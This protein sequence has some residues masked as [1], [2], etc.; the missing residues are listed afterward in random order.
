MQNVCSKRRIKLLGTLD[1]SGNFISAKNPL[2]FLRDPKEVQS[3]LSL[4][5]LRAHDCPARAKRLAI[6]HP[7][8]IFCLDACLASVLVAMRCVRKFND[9]QRGSHL[10][11]RSLALLETARDQLAATDLGIRTMWADFMASAGSPRVGP[12]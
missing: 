12:T 3:Q 11:S 4:L 6:D 10:C 7:T 9:E 2:V 8:F 1:D 5:V